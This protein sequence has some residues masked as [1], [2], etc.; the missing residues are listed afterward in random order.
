MQCR[1][2]ES[3]AVEAAVGNRRTMYATQRC[4]GPRRLARWK[5]NKESKENRN[6]G[7][8]E[9]SDAFGAARV[10]NGHH[11]ILHGRIDSFS[12]RRGVRVRKSLC[13]AIVTYAPEAKTGVLGVPQETIVQYGL[14]S[15]PVSPAMARGVM[16]L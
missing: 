10:R 4:D 15:E 2:G 12:H 9:G 1:T 6:G 11:G 16:R 3:G 7:R 13:L 5:G 14:T 8:T